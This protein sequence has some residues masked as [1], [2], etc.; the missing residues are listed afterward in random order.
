MDTFRQVA[1]I[2]LFLSFRK[3]YVHHPIKYKIVETY[4]TLS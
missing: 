3:E 2:T 4:W 1:N